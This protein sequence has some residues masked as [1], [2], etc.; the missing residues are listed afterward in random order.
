MTSIS[1]DDE[2]IVASL[3]AQH[4]VTPA[5]A[6]VDEFVRRYRGARKAAD[7]L[8]TMPGVRYAEPA[9]TFDPRNA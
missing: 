2:T 7:S 9:M 5:Q 6:E 1:P 4:G 8:Y 3:L